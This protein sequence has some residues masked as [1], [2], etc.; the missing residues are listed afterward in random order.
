[1]LIPSPTD[2]DFSGWDFFFKSTTGYCLFVYRTS[3]YPWWNVQH[4]SKSHMFL[5]LIHSCKKWCCENIISNSVDRLSLS[6]LLCEALHLFPVP[7]YLQTRS[8]LYIIPILFCGKLCR[9]KLL[10]TLCFLLGKLLLCWN[11]FILFSCSGG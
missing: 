11:P 4:R 9:Y 8:Y 6:L 10:E 2:L 7:C 1:M 5:L 3:H